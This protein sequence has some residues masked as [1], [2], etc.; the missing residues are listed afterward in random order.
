[1]TQQ[2]DPAEFEPKVWGK[3]A[4]FKRPFPYTAPSGQRVLLKRLDM[5]DILKMGIA[6]DLD[7]MT[8]ALAAE[9]EKPK[10]EGEETPDEGLSMF[11]VLAK[12]KNFDKLEK[13][14]NAVCVTGVIAPK[15][16]LPPLHENARQLGLL[17]V[18]DIPF[19]D[20]FVMFGEIFDMEGIATFREES[21]DGMGSV[22]DVADVP[23]PAE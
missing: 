1:M 10:A 17:Y 13:A 21:T 2:Y 4:D 11:S 9:P 7:F 20:R 15:L 16:H 8:K 6:E 12:S 23:L 14:I 22:P 3:N 19:N 5:A 18:T